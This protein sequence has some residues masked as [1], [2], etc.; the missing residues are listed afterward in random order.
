MGYNYS[1]ELLQKEDNI[2]LADRTGSR[3]HSYIPDYV[4]FD[5]E[6]TGISCARDEVVEISA[7][8]VKGGQVVDEFNTLVN[9]GRLIP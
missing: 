3:L 7:V 4:V 9:P 6:T 8:K 5:L 1:K 2:M